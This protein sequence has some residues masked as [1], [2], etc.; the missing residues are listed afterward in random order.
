MRKQL[1]ILGKHY[2]VAFVD[3]LPGCIGA[4]D[5]GKLTIAIE[6]R[7]KDVMLTTMVHEILEAINNDQD[8]GLRHDIINLLELGIFDTLTRNGVDLEPLLEDKHGS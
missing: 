3:D 7:P 2:S 8:L 6:R 1:N 4:C 5:H